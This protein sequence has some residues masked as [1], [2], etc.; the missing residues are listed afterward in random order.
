MAESKIIEQKILDNRKAILQTIEEHA[1]NGYVFTSS[2][3][4]LPYLTNDELLAR[5]KRIKP[6]VSVNGSYYYLK[7]Y[8]AS[9]MRSRAY[10][11]NISRDIRGEVDMTDAEVIAEFPCY[12]PYCYVGFF[13]PTIAEVLQQ[14]PDNALDKAN[15]FYMANSLETIFDLN[16]QAEIVHAGC[17]QSTVK[18]LVLKK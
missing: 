2:R 1:D 8:N 9:M 16:M 15:A 14:F 17:H 10:L 6:I 12:H 11:W 7:R 4:I 18:A 3:I 13:K 5:Y